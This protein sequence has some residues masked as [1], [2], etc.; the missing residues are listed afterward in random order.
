VKSRYSDNAPIYKGVIYENSEVGAKKIRATKFFYN[1]MCGNH[2]IWGATD[3]MEFEARHVG[4]VRDKVRL[5]EMQ[6]RKY[7][8]ESMSNEEQKFKA[9]AKKVIAATKEDVLDLLFG[10]RS[11]ALS[12]KV[13]D[14]G[15]DAVVKEQ[16]GQPNTV[17][18]M[19]QGLTRHSQTLPYADAR[20][21]IDK[22]A[23]K[24]LDM[25]DAF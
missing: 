1:G 6:I 2:C 8:E 13:L 23:G 12:R 4:N 14:A 19:V 21:Q 7:A 22:A 24:L 5:F 11:L 10:K 17:W 3:V 9:A 15:Y 18:G 20:T 25:V 16:D